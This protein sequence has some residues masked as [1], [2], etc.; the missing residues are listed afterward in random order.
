M[1]SKFALWIFP[2]G[3]I[4]LHVYMLYR[5]QFYKPDVMPAF[6][7]QIFYMKYDILNTF[8]KVKLLSVKIFVTV[9]RNLKIEI[10]LLYF[11]VRKNIS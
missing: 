11:Q 2:S 4:T 3:N 9:T 8:E 5:P 10:T 7:S 1:K 6:K